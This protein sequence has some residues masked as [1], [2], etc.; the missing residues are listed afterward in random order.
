MNMATEYKNGTIEQVKNLYQRFV[1]QTLSFSLPLIGVVC[2]FSPQ[3]VHFLFQKIHGRSSF[4]QVVC[5][6][7]YFGNGW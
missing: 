2:L 7:L 5:F 4:F 6:D 1:V 3:I